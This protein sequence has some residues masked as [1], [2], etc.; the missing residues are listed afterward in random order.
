M[1]GIIAAIAA[2]VVLGLGRMLLPIEIVVP[3]T[4]VTFVVVHLFNPL[5]HL[6]RS[7]SRPGSRK[8]NRGQR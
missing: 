2:L 3:A 1:R 4:M 5:R 7:L 8:R 6:K